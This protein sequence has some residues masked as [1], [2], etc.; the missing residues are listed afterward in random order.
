MGWTVNGSMGVFR[1]TK[2]QVFESKREMND[3]VKGN[4]ISL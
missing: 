3:G 2:R 4:V 1:S